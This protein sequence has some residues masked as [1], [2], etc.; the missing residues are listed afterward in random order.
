MDSCELVISHLDQLTLTI[1]H[2]LPILEL[3]ALMSTNEMWTRTYVE[4]FVE[5]RWFANAK[6]IVGKFRVENFG[7]A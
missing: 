7:V 5:L 4:F 6:T 2:M 3:T 1:V